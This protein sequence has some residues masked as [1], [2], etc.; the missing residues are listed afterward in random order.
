MSKPMSFSRN[1]SSSSL[2]TLLHTSFL[3]NAVPWASCLT[4]RSGH[5]A[6][7]SQAP[8]GEAQASL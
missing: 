2:V 7:G 8:A 1:P 4:H 6:V 3:H 5:V